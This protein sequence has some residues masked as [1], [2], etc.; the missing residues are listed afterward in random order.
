MVNTLSVTDLDASV[1]AVLAAGGSVV[2]AR[3]VVPGVGYLAYCRDTE[4]NPFG[5]M[6]SDMSA[7]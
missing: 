6:Q 2:E 4:G 7:Q 1:A 5:M 3:M